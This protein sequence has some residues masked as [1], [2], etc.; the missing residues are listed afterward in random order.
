MGSIATYQQVSVKEGIL[1][2]PEKA[3]ATSIDLWEK[4]AA[5]LGPL[6][7]Q[8][9]FDRLFFRSLHL[10]NLR[11]YQINVRHPHTD[12]RPYRKLES[13]FVGQS[14]E[15]GNHGSVAL[16]N[17]FIDILVLL[18]GERLTAKILDQAWSDIQQT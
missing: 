15:V 2:H 7:G 3:L 5:V 11:I 18:L 6:I 17:S 8:R 1:A 12:S 4:L 9:D 13:L 10:S 14:V 16:L